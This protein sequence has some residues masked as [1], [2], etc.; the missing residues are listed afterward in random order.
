MD[1]LERFGVYLHS[2]ILMK[3]ND[4]FAECYRKPFKI[5]ELHRMYSVSKT[6]AAMAIGILVGDGKIG[7]KDAVIKY[8][9]EYDTENVSEHVRKLTVKHLLKMT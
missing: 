8:F 3:G 7:L 5:N 9:P 4:I 1:G 2:F 6:F